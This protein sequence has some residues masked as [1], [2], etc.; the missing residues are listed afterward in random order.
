MNPIELE[1][2]N[3]VMPPDGSRE[4]E[5]QQDA[6]V[7]VQSNS[8]SWLPGFNAVLHWGAVK[9]GILDTC[10]MPFITQVSGEQIAA[11]TSTKSEE[12]Y[13]QNTVVLVHSKQEF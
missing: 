1:Q 8:R 6:A 4:N 2:H 7:T 11:A 10:K 3:T 5:R 13:M 12:R 9:A